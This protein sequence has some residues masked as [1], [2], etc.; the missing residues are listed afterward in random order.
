MA[1][2]VAQ[3]NTFPHFGLKTVGLVF[4][5]LATK[6]KQSSP[7]QD[8]LE[9][10]QTPVSITPVQSPPPESDVS[11]SMTSAQVCLSKDQ[12]QDA[13]TFYLILLGTQPRKENW[14]TQTF[15]GTVW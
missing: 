8:F 15:A 9:G 14:V 1:L 10:L 2:L 13:P 12:V 7:V 4:L 3:V 5:L 11:C 6:A